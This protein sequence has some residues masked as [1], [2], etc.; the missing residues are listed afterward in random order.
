MW[1]LPSKGRAAACRKLILEMRRLGASGR[2]ALC[3]NEDDGQLSD[4]MDLR[5]PGDLT[6]I[7][8]PS[9]NVGSA[10]CI[11][12][13][14]SRFPE[15]PWYGLI[16]DDNYPET[17]GFEGRLI[18]AAGNWSIASA[19]DL[20]Q[21]DTNPKKSRMHGATVFGGDLVRSVG[22]IAPPGF[23]HLFIDDVWENIGRQL[24]N[25]RTLMDVIVR[26]DHPFKSGKTLDKTHSDA[27]SSA[28]YHADGAAYNRWFSEEF[29]S[30]VHNVRMDIWASRGLSLDGLS[31][32][33][34]LFGLPCYDK[35]DPKR[36]TCLLD[37]VY[38]LAQFGV[39][40]GHVSVVGQTIH[41][42]RNTIA[43]A[44]MK[45]DFT[46]LFF[47]DADMTF[48]AWDVLKFIAAPHPLLAAVGRKRVDKPITDP[49]VW[50]FSPREDLDWNMPIDDHGM[51]EVAQVGTGFMR[52]RR[53]V[54]EAIKSNNQGLTRAKDHERTKFYTKYF[55]WED[56]GPDEI[57]ED[58]T[59]CRRYAATGGKIWIDPTVH[60]GHIGA[61][62]W[63]G[64]VLDIME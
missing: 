52:I 13:A 33:S 12:S 50:C 14:V 17:A 30:I 38:L 64:C 22:Y 36:E 45:S 19:N 1:I 28:A 44:F 35:V 11:R 15:E 46:D 5:C 2:I 63:H 41:Q 49:S 60:L 57:S 61:N 39:R 9:G 51:C 40:V 23:A 3:V 31:G 47:I 7:T 16:A 27:N 24:G 56:D 21:A 26:H 8:I 53:E 6:V 48:S 43:D 54:F 10:E 25:W 29:P 20:W 42:A 58:I 37:T 32:K 34:V 18:S 59:F 55:S 62:E 4:Y